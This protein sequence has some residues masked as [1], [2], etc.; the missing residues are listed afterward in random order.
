MCHFPLRYFALEVL[1]C[2][3]PPYSAELQRALLPL[4]ADPDIFEPAT[5]KDKVGGEEEG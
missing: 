5:A 1:D 2:I 4:V 3:A